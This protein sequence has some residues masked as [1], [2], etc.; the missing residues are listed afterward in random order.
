M[1]QPTGLRPAPAP[2][3]APTGE[4]TVLAAVPDVPV[5]GGVVLVDWDVVVTQPVP[6]TFKA[7]SADT[8]W[9]VLAG[10]SLSGPRSVVR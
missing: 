2:P 1:P 6:G 5:G 3:A 9:C 4:G 8:F 10:A 7:F